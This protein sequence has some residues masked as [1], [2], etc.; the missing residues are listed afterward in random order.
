MY[1]FRH[2]LL[3]F[4]SVI[5]FSFICA[6]HKATVHPVHAAMIS[7]FA[8][9][10]Q[11]RVMRIFA[12]LSMAIRFRCTNLYDITV[13]R[14]NQ[15]RIGEKFYRRIKALERRIRALILNRNYP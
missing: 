4:C 9:R 12:A 3:G 7:D 11:E 15:D 10:K 6:F 14:I 8:V 2:L 13:G 1:P 5:H